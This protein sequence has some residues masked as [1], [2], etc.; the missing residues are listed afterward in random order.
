MR[1]G[2]GSKAKRMSSFGPNGFGM[3]ECL[4]YVLRRG[5]VSWIAEANGKS[6]QVLGSG[7]ESRPEGFYGE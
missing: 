2:N 4:L 3:G 5:I 6:G 1:R 7:H